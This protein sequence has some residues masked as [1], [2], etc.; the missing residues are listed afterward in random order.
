LT[1]LTNVE[2][3]VVEAMK[4]PG[5]QAVCSRCAISAI[6]ILLDCQIH[7]ESAFANLMTTC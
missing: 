1:N 4:P 7:T 5:A 3:T 6:G 2:S